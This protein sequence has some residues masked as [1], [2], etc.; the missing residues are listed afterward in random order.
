MGVQDSYSETIRKGVPGQQADAQPSAMISKTA[1]DAAGVGFGRVVVR[2][3][4]DEAC[5]EIASGD[6][7]G[8]FL[9]FSVRERS[10]AAE[11]NK[12][13][14]YD[15]VRIMIRG[16]LWVTAGVAVNDGDPVYVEPN[17]GLLRT[18]N[19]NSAFLLPNWVWDTTVSAPGLAKIRTVV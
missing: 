7:V 18:T 11:N 13:V 15:S 8:V 5:R 2:G 9:G 12:F 16:S 3:S 17:G 10:V 19:A 6:A 14:R 1:Q 4:T